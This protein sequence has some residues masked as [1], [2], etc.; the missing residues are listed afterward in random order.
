MVEVCGRHPRCFTDGGALQEMPLHPED[1]TSDWSHLAVTGLARE[2]AY[3]WDAL[4]AEIKGR[5]L[6]VSPWLLIGRGPP[7]PRPRPAPSDS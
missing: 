4:P 2:A 6:G 7:G 3:A 1:L 5:R